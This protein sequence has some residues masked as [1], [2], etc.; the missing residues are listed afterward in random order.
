[1]HVFVMFDTT[2]DMGNPFMEESG[3]WYILESKILTEV[4]CRHLNCSGNRDA[5]TF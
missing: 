3:N 1:M 2:D 5:G 4:G